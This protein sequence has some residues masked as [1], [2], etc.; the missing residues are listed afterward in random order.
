[1]KGERAIFGGDKDA[2]RRH[3]EEVTR[4][5]ARLLQTLRQELA[6]RCADIE[7]EQNNP[8]AQ[9]YHAAEA[10]VLQCQ[11]DSIIKSEAASQAP[12]PKRIIVN[13]KPPRRKRGAKA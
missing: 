8:D 13:S 9:R 4:F 2:I 1:M 3:K 7:A 5:N 10:Y 12:K 6:E 11:I